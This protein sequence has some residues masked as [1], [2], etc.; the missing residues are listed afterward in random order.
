MSHSRS[1]ERIVW[2][3]VLASLGLVVVLLLDLWPWLRGGYGWRW[4]YDRPRLSDL[5]RLWPLGLT[6]A[7][8]GG[9]LR[10]LRSRC[11]DLY[12]AWCFLGA[13]AVPL[14]CLAWSGCPL[15]LLFTRTVSALTTGGFT[16]GARVV[17]PIEALRRWPEYMLS[18]RDFSS[19]MAISPPGWPLAY[20]LLTRALE[21]LPTLAERLAL[22]LRTFQCH[23]IPLMRLSNPQIASA[24]LGIAAPLWAAAAA[25]PLYALARRL[26]D[27]LTARWAVALWP[28]VPSLALFSGTL[29]TPYPLLS[30]TAAWLFGRGLTGPR[31]RWL[32]LGLAGALSAL[33]IAFSLSFVPL[34]LLFGLW[35]LLHLPWTRGRSAD[36]ARRA[37]S[38]G[39]AYALGLA[40]VVAV[41]VLLGANPLAILRT[42]FDF[43]LHHIDRP[44]WPWLALHTWDLGLFMGVPLC[45]LAL[46]ASRSRNAGAAGPLAL[47]TTLT[48]AAQV[49]SGTGRGE[50][51]RIWLFFMP[52]WL[53]GAALI[54]RD[55]SPRA[56]RAAL[57]AQMVWLLVCVM[58]LRTV[59]TG[60]HA[61]PTWVEVSVGP[62]SPIIPIAEARFGSHLAL[63]GYGAQQEL[64]AEALTLNL[65]WRIEGQIDAPY[66]F[67]AL[68][69]SPQGPQGQAVDW[70]PFDVRY[71]TTCWH[72]TDDPSALVD[73]VTLPLES[74]HP[75]GD[76]WLSLSAFVLDADG[77]P[78]R[79]PVRTPSG[80]L[81]EQLGLGPIPIVVY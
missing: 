37:A 15:E 10:L 31:R 70:Q 5:K 54:L 17:D 36:S 9:G 8:Y 43:H 57:A 21:R 72:L 44:Y 75:S 49:L 33:S 14:A 55:L 63:I 47:A 19:H 40:L 58:V 61:P 52:L 80:E 73:H 76:W 59:G 23:N 28:L 26:T 25:L 35:T 56:R 22:P 13:I 20:A 2:L 38:V 3:V 18:A 78:N 1:R 66:Y 30:V 11:T 50:T 16:L 74:G 71:P 27:A 79:L 65:Q 46:L 45:A 6:L 81:D 69:V 48:I 39:T 29:S 64:G 77:S 7:L 51:G 67:S 12:V 34:I 41:G 42:S 68:L 62:T 24:W 32:W 4:P 53:G 60:L